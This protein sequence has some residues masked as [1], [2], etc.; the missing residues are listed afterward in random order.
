LVLTEG[1]SSCLVLTEGDS[2]CRFHIPGG[3]AQLLARCQLLGIYWAGALL[4]KRQITLGRN[5]S[6]VRFLCQL[7][8]LHAIENL[9]GGKQLTCTIHCTVNAPNCNDDFCQCERLLVSPYTRPVCLH[10]WPTAWGR[11]AA[12]RRVSRIKGLSHGIEIR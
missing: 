9:R 4:E 11:A 12:L 5:C 3:R 10:S 8:I 6:P 1:D 7:K 2:S